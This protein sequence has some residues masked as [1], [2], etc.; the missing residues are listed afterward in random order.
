VDYRNASLRP[1]FT[2]EIS[3]WADR[4]AHV[5][6]AE[7]VV[8]LARE[9][10]ASLPPELIARLPQDCQ[11]MQIKY[12]D[13]LDFWAYRLVQHYHS[14]S[15]KRIDGGL[16]GEL[17]DFLLHALIRLAELHRTLPGP[18]RPLTQ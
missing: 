14:G 13:D 6:N 15:E 7:Q 1:G 18:V 5:R 3:P 12:E 16:L 17:I 11:P 4:F 2:G 9:Y 8:A 10:L